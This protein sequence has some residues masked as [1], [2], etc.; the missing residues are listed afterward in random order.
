MEFLRFGSRIPGSYWGCCAVCIIQDFKQKPDE[1]ASIEVVEGD[2]GVPIRDFVTNEVKFLG[3]TWLDIFKQRL[4]IGTFSDSDMPNHT[5]FA[6]L[7]DYQ[8]RESPGK[9]WLK[10]LKEHG[11]E[12]V[13]TVDN[14]VYTGEEDI[15]EPGEGTSPSHKNHIFALFRNIGNGYVTDPYTPP[16]EWTDLP[17]VV[18]EFWDYSKVSG[19]GG[20]LNLEVQ[21]AQLQLWRELPERE[22]Y[23]EKELEAAGVPVILAGRR[24]D[25][26]QQLKKER[27][28]VEEK[29]RKTTGNTKAAPFFAQIPAKTQSKETF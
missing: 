10:I 15:S 6:V 27:E 5:F 8:I 19:S 3:K 9:D 24:S 4:R 16:K 2:N 1:P 18:P 20:D 25:K 28:L 17:N 12:F 21:E 11:F 22:F 14:S 13:R 26:P 23:S 29:K 7:T